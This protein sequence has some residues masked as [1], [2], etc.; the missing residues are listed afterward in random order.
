MSKQLRKVETN[1]KY[2]REQIERF[3]KF[4]YGV[5]YRIEVYGNKTIEKEGYFSRIEFKGGKPVAIDI[6]YQLMARGKKE[7]IL[8]AALRE[9]L[10][11]VFWYRRKPYGETS[12]EYITEL[13]RYN[14]PVY[15]KERQ[16]GKDLHTYGCSACKRIY[17]LRERKLPQTKDITQHNLITKCCGK[18]F[19]YVGKVYYK[20]VDLYRISVQLKGIRRRE[21]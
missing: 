16:T 17:V 11:V 18:P 2:A 19:E 9:A 7:D 3:M 5:A 8:K 15:G 1:I 10:K 20:G 4:Q 13:R 21:E 12:S 6:S 14:F